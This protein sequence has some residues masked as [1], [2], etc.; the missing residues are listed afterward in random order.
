ML[1]I[2]EYKKEDHS[3]LIEMISMVLAEHKMSID[4]T[5]PDKD[6]QDLQNIY[7]LNNGAFFIAKLDDRIIGSVAVSKIDDESSELR[8]LYVLKEY[9]NRGFGKILLDKAIDFASSN[10]YRKMELEVSK[11]HQKAI[12]LYQQAGFIKSET[13]SCCPRCD[14]IY[15][16]SLV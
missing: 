1:E 6:L 2:R 3:Q 11:K 13:Q 12:S 4:F 8:K 5:G 16:K 9:R 14:F 10:R 15:T 7:F